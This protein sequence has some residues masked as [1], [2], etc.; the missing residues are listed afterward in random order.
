MITNVVQLLAYRIDFWLLGI[1]YSNYEVGLYAQA[2]KFANLAWIIPNILAQL[3]IPKFSSLTRPATSGVFRTAIYFNIISIFFTITCTLFF[4]T[5]YLD[6][7]YKYG[8]RAFFLM[9]PGYFFWAGVIY[10]GAYFSWMGK[11]Y[12]NL[13]GSTVCFILI[14]AADL[15]LIPKYSISGAAIANSM[16]YFIVFVIY[17]FILRK[18][19]S[20]S[21]GELMVLKKNDFYNALKLLS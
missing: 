10:F 18:K 13:L 11:F 12:Y 9:L 4:Y 3:L 15:I 14:F 21:L 1:Y 8:L 5:F 16:V 6:A 2:N 7:E 19:Q 20:F 17:I